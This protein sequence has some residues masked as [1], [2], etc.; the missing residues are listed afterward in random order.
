MAMLD[1]LLRVS[2]RGFMPSYHK[3][4]EH[5]WLF[6]LGITTAMTP[7]Y[8]STPPPSSLASPSCWKL[9]VLGY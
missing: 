4:A 1:Q 2:P 7:K 6:G 5:L 9:L 8:S 3:S